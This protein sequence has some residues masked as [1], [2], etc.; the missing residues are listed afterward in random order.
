MGFIGPILLGAYQLGSFYAFHELSVAAL[1]IPLMFVI[2]EIVY[3]LVE[4]STYR[5]SNLRNRARHS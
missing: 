2:A 5:L 4:Y 3:E 1:T